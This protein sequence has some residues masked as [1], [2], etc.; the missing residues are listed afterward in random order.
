M[1]SAATH[2]SIFSRRGL[3]LSV[4]LALLAAST[5]LQAQFGTTIDGHPLTKLAP[6]GTHAVVLFFVA[7]DCPIS[8][9]TFPEMK[10]LREQFSS[11]GVKFYFVYPNSTEHTADIAAHQQA[12][13]PGGE[14]LLDPKGDLVR[15]TH[16]RVT[17]EVSVLVPTETGWR[18]VYTGRI[19]DRYIH[20]GLER[21]RPTHIFAEE[22]LKAIL[23]G[24]PA[25]KPTGT[26]VGCA[27]VSPAINGVSA[28]R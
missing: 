27:I 1:L 9:R 4:A 20:L 28:S 10:R 14:L 16:T 19:D 3:L 15:L 8:D 17:P 23:S 26:P 12:F 24:K 25:P 5:A 7:S 6:D 21:P 11:R 18:S 22:A 2:L 13:D